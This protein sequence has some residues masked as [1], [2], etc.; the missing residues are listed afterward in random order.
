MTHFKPLKLIAL[1]VLLTFSQLK[2]NAQFVVS[3]PLHTAVTQL[4]KLLQDPSFKTL[5]KNVEKLKKVT[6]GVQQFHRGTQLVSTIT[7]TTTM[8]NRM[9]NS[10]GKDGHIYPAEYQM[11]IQD[12]QGLT[13]AGTDILK[14]M[15]QSTSQNILE[16]NDSERMNWLNMA[17]ERAGKFQ[18]LV[19]AYYNRIRAMS[20]RRAGNLRDRQATAKLYDIALANVT[21]NPLGGDFNFNNGNEQAYDAFYPEGTSVLDNYTET[22]DAVKMR[23]AQEDFNK[24]LLNYQDELQIAEMK[25]QRIALRIKLDE[26]YRPV[27]NWAG[28]KTVGWATPDGKEISKEEFE[29]IVKI[30]GR[31][32]LVPMREE[33]TKKYRIDEGIK[34]K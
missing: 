25:A 24:R 12:F 7:Q 32:L 31:E 8:L 15:R 10:I 34:L 18:N 33:L 28:T 30:L 22:E 5:V 6:S 9:A 14:D 26:G 29:V 27:E 11:I 3:D 20:M 19:Q 23:Q 4:I 13:K 17:H 21:S 1:T 16:M 2:V